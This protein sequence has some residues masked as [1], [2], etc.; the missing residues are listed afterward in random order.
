M[1][2]R[3]RYIIR[4]DDIAETIHVERFLLLK[5]KLIS[6]NIRP[7]IGVVP[8]N[9]DEKLLQFP[10]MTVHFWSFIRDLQNSYNW[11]VF[12]HGTYHIYRTENSGILNINPKSEFAGLTLD[13]QTE[14]LNIGFNEFVKN[15][16]I[17]N[18][19][20]A[21]SHSFDKNTLIAL[22]GLGIDTITDG[23]GLFPNRDSNNILWIPQ[24]FS[25]FR[26]FFNFNGIYT[27]CIHINT[28]SDAEFNLL[29]EN[30]EKFE[31]DFVSVD[32]VQRYQ[33]IHP[34][35]SGIARKFVQFLV[36]FSFLLYR[37]FKLYV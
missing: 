29:F 12:Q 9:G 21:P 13:E 36:W 11:S 30:L 2:N 7:I 31:E 25:S 35:Q 8:L 32:I 15:D 34:K 14:L 5:A 37:K 24:L 20:M 19:F 33:S 6:L 28:M 3:S 27:V 17:V 1:L 4:L 16:I 26:N 22:K 18:G 10:L 23:F